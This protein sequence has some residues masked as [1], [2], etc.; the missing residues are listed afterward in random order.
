MTWLNV[1]IVGA[2]ILGLTY[3]SELLT[4]SVALQMHIYRA[5][6]P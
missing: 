1:D 4:L 3:S 5:L 2:Q 6:L